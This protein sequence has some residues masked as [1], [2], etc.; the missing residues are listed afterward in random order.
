MT[1]APIEEGAYSLSEE[2]GPLVGTHRVEIESRDLGG[3]SMDDEQAIQRLKEQGVK[4]LEVVKVPVAYNKR[5]QLT[6]T[7]EADTEN[8]FD[9]Q[10]SS[11][12]R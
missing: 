5:S 12:P 8:Q 6:A 3:V 2:L 7:V 9:F 11:K 4:R 1:T 10:L